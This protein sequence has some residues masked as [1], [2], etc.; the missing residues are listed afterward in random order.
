MDG[1]NLALSPNVTLA[2]QGLMGSKG[3]RANI[4]STNFGKIGMGVID[5]GI[6]GEV[7]C[8]EFTD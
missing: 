4:L 8:Q 2:M 7:F 5:G 6:I 1:E 3:H